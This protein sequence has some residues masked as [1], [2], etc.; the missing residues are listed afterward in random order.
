MQLKCALHTHSG[1]DPEDRLSYSAYDLLDQAKKLGFDVFA[2]THHNSFFFTEEIQKCAKQKNI[3]LIPGIEIDIQNRH[4]VI[5]GANKKCEQIQSFADLKK[6]KKN[7]LES[8]VLAP[9]PYFPMFPPQSL[10]KY[11]KK[12]IELF[13]GVELSWFYTKWIDFNRRAKKIAH[14]Y[15]LPLIA[16]PDCHTISGLENGYCTVNAEHK[17]IQS[18]V[19]ALQKND[20]VNHSEPSSI[21]KLVQT[22]AK[23]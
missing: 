17:T 5:L 19:R 9:H 15:D 18:V 1:E 6:W 7:N 8:F 23:M 11:L 21:L 22:Y 12:N 2:F 10:G 14:K 16:T 4:V 20:F 13:D 3:L